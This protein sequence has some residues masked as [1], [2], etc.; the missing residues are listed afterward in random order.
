MVNN[1]VFTRNQNSEKNGL[2]MSRFTATSSSNGGAIG[3][4]GKKLRKVNQKGG[5]NDL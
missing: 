4:D 3:A 1:T 2:A 5:A